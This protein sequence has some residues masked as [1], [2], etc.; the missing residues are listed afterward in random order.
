MHGLEPNPLQPP[1][2]P[3]G[4]QDVD[5]ATYHESACGQRELRVAQ[6]V[7]VPGR[8]QPVIVHRTIA[9]PHLP[10]VTMLDPR[11]N[12]CPVVVG[13]NRVARQGSVSYRSAILN[14]HR[15]EGWVRWDYLPSGSLE[16]EP[17]QMGLSPEQWAE[18]RVELRDERAAAT[19]LE[20][21]AYEVQSGDKDVLEALKGNTEALTRLLDKVLL[22]GGPSKRGKGADA[23]GE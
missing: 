19:A 11:G 12:I 20:A 17:A 4:T 2:T 6:A 5:S 14:N 3:S 22:Q 16:I 15:R 9:V 7:N 23:G 1:W 13:N 10:Y 18:K 21:K 8:S